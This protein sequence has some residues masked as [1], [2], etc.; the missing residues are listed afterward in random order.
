MEWWLFAIIG[1]CSATY[2][3]GVFICLFYLLAIDFSKRGT[4][5]IVKGD[6][7]KPYWPTALF[8]AVLSPI[9]VPWWVVTFIKAN[10]GGAK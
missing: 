2:V 6:V 1:Y 3:W 5:I 7:N 8:Y 9:F 10:S 4:G